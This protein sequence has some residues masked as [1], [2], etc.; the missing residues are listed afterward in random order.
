MFNLIRFGSVPRY[1]NHCFRPA[2]CWQLVALIG[3]ILTPGPAAADS[4][5]FLFGGQWE[6]TK[7]WQVMAEGGIGNRRQVILGAFFRF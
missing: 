2:L 4:G 7:R 1:L 3:L 6:I 5:N